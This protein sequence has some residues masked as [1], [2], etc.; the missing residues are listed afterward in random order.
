MYLSLPLP[1]T[2]VRTMTLTVMT[3]DGSSQQSTVTVTVPKNGKLE[4][5]IQALGN[6]CSIGLDESL[7]V[8]EVYITA[9]IRYMLSFSFGCCR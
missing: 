1:S 5:L 9:L 3:T 2:S 4:D 8:A 7:L 6:A